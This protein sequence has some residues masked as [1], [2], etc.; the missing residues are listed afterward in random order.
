MK[1]TIIPADGAVYK[2]G[3]CVSNLDLSFAPQDVHALQ[4]LDTKG[5]VEFK[6]NENFNKPENKN[7]TSLPEWAEQSLLKWEEANTA[8]IAAQNVALQTAEQPTEQA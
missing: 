1:I 6:V 5:W 8:F 4:W 2:D 3:A 7:I